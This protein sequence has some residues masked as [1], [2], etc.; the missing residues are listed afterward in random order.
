MKRVMVIGCPG[1]GKST[2]SKALHKKTSLPLFH[3]DLMNWNSDRSTVER[4]IFIERLYKAIQKD[5]WIIDGDYG[6]TIEIRLKACDTVFFLDYP[7]EICLDGVIG[8]RGKKRSDMP[9]VEPIDEVDEE[10]IEFIY[11]Y[12]KVNRP[13]VLHLLE[14]YSDKKIFIFKNREEASNYLEEI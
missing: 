6:S 2:F 3:L 7:V 8:R 11:N 10:F 13:S 4:N 5:E 14:K 9:W 1:S 12:N